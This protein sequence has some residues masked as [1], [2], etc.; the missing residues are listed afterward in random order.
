M[1]SKKKTV[2]KPT[3][4]ISVRSLLRHP[5]PSSASQKKRRDISQ[6]RRIQSIFR[7]KY[8][9]F[10]SEIPVQAEYIVR[11]MRMQVRGR[12][13]GFYRSRNGWKLIEI[14]LDA[15]LS[16]FSFTMIEMQEQLRYYAAL[17]E[18]SVLEGREQKM[19][20]G[21]LAFVGRGGRLQR[22][23]VSLDDATQALLD[24]LEAELAAREDRKSHLRSLR[25]SWPSISRKMR[26]DFRPLQSEMS[27]A[28]VEG[29]SQNHLQILASPPGTGKTRAVL[30]SGLNQAIAQGIPLVYFTAKTT[31]AQEALATLKQMTNAGLPLRTVWFL[32]LAQL[33]TNC[34]EWPACEAIRATHEAIVRGKIQAFL[35]KQPRWSPEEIESYCHDER[36]CHYE[37]NREAA[38]LADVII[39]DEYFFFEGPPPMHRKPV[40]LIDEVHQIP[41]RLWCHIETQLSIEEIRSLRSLRGEAAQATRQWLGLLESSQFE[42]SD[43][44]IINRDD[45]IHLG[46]SLRSYVEAN[47]E[48]AG[49]GVIEKVEHIARWISRVPKAV[50]LRPVFQFDGFNGYH[51]FLRDHRVVMHELLQPYSKVIGF[52]GTL[53][54]D[55]DSLRHLLG[56]PTSTVILRIGT[57]EKERLRVLII[58]KG[59]T[60]FPL[61]LTDFKK[62]VQLLIQVLRIRPGVYLVFGPRTYLKNKRH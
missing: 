36:Y 22:M 29:L 62:A 45:W 6:H 34:P 40:A 46:K 38:R 2:S 32:G 13:D 52:S 5:D 41:E 20:S 54:E 61:R 53:P 51:L 3:I 4:V 7:R 1:K 12:L 33:C 42:M 30:W 35:T 44:V 48:K 57:A 19:L 26:R 27:D 24:R 25:M 15:S 47:S 9:T 23:E 11:G 60:K 56:F 55:D 39:A 59:R 50:S 58:P 14:K 49:S 17:A 10:R 31:G 8:K 21:E 16:S 28:L 18:Q 37:V 43:E